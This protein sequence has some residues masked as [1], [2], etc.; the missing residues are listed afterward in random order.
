ML[1]TGGSANVQHDLL[2]VVES[3]LC[4]TPLIVF[5]VFVGVPHDSAPHFFSAAPAAIGMAKAIAQSNSFV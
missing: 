1:Q 5:W 4:T 2:Q 3:Q